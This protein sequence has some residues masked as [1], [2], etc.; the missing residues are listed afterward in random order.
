M[1]NTLSIVGIE[2]T[3]FNIVKIIYDK[4]TANIVVNLEKN[5][6]FSYKIRNQ[7]MMPTPTAPFQYGTGNLSQSNQARQRNQGY[8]GQKGRSKAVFFV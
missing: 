7:A 3:Y 5:E 8:S 2:G 6:S 1:I 4:P